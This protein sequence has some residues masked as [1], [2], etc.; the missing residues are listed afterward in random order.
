MKILYLWFA[1][2]LCNT[3]HSIHASWE[4][5][6]ESASLP[7]SKKYREDLRDRLDKIDFS[8]ISHDERVKVERLRSLLRED[9]NDTASEAT[10]S[11]YVYLTG[12]FGVGLICSVYY[13]Y[14]YSRNGVI[15]SSDELRRARE[16]KYQ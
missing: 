4:E 11:N 16:I 9:Y 12:L 10:L 13:L 3:C 15:P 7:M 5:Y 8:R 14:V 1:L 2:S 6:S